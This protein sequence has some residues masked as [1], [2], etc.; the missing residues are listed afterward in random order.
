MNRVVIT[1]MGIYSCIGKNLEEVR[2][3]LY[4]GRSGIILDPVRKEYGYRSGLTGYVDKPDLKGKLDRRAR[5]MLPEQGEYAYLATIEALAN[6]GIDADHIQ[7]NEIGILYGND[8]SGKAV[9]EAD[10]IIRE[11]KD[12]TLVGSGAVFQTM[13]STVTMNLATIFKLRGINFTISAACASGSHSIGLG[14]HFIKTG[15]QDC[16]ICGG[17]Q[18]INHLSMGTFDAL[19]AFSIRE[20]D[21]TRASRPFDRD[22]DG[23]I[24]SGGA[25]TVILE[26]LESAQKRGAKILGEVIGYG[27]SSNGGHISNPTVEG[28]VRSL[29]RALKDAGIDAKEIDY[30]NAHATS[31]PAGDASEARA[32]DEV[33]G[34]YKPLV[35]STKSMTGHECWMAGASEIVYSLLMMQN[36]FVAPNINFENPDEDSAKLNIAKS[37]I[38]K[39]IVVFLSNSFGFGGTNSSLIIRKLN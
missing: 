12:T 5:I 11:K 10:D 3:S 16:I 23:L 17:A 32:I 6:A 25:A 30:I 7:A 27:F 36:S 26:S 31:T 20:S 29:H 1:G 28:P 38:E 15:L 2:D 13:N 39:D 9:I 24:P 22:R 34:Q 8:S 37:A 4:K 35:S 19:S 14:Y 18:E 33:F 21:P